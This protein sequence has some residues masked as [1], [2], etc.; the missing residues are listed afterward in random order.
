MIW[1]WGKDRSGPW[2][3]GWKAWCPKCDAAIVESGGKC[4][5]CGFK[6]RR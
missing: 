1:A 3:Y 4:P 6:Q 5:K 2:G